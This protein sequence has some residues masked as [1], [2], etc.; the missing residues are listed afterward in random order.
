MYEK[1]DTFEIFL[2]KTDK[3]VLSELFSNVTIIFVA[4]VFLVLKTHS[5]IRENF[6]YI[7]KFS[8]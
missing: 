1:T 3:S 5:R 8:I 4:V 6:C 7:V 2:P